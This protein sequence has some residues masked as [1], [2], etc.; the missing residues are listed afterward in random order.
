MEARRARKKSVA[1]A[2]LSLAIMAAPLASGAG[3]EA[4]INDDGDRCVP[5]PV[6]SVMKYEDGGLDYQFKTDEG[7]VHMPV[8]PA[9]W[10][11]LTASDADL[12]RYGYPARPAGE[13]DLSAWNQDWATYKST[14]TPSLCV[15]PASDPGSVFNST[16]YSRNW[17]GYISEAASGNH[18]VAASGEY[19]QPAHLS[20]PCAG[21]KQSEWVGLGGYQRRSDNSAGLIQVGTGINTSGPYAWYEWVGLD[22]SG[23]SI[24]IPQHEITSL[25]IN[26]G[27]HIHVSVFYATSNDQADFIVQN[28]TTGTSQ[29]VLKTVNQSAFFDGRDGDFIIER[30]TSSTTGILPM[31][32]FGHIDWNAAKVENQ[33]GDWVFL[34]NTHDQIKSVMTS[35]GLSSGTTFVSTGSIGGSS[36]GSFTSTYQACS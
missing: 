24:G 28:E 5:I 8:P 6:S 10:S 11:P 35:N 22:S 1:I 33:T 7:I 27:D 12:A 17:G 18:Y 26:A 31:Q 3:A 36:G 4:A 9:G 15:V 34:A 16:D 19:D 21:N 30:P 29:S 20:T 14:P 2:G 23:N 13:D 32:N 25:N